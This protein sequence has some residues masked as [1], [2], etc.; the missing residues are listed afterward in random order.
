M[1]INRFSEKTSK[2]I[3]TAQFDIQAIQTF[4]KE[5]TNED[6]FQISKSVYTMIWFQQGSGDISIELDHF[7]IEESTLYYIKPGQT[8]N[9][10]IDQPAKGFIISF[11]KEFVELYE[12]NASELNNCAL[13][14]H[15]WTSPV[16][17]INEETN[18]FMKNI[19]DKMLQEFK[20]CFELRTEVLKSFLKIFIIYLSRQFENNYQ[21]P[22]KPRKMEMVNIF[23]TVLE[24]NFATKKMVRDYAKILGVS[25]GYLN[26]MVKEISGFTASYHIQQRVILE[27]KR[28]AIFEGD[29][30]KEISYYLGFCDPA[31][32]S[33]YFKNTSGKNFT[34]FKK[35]A[36]SFC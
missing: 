32:F 9:A 18:S 4:P 35:G 31:H 6:A 13:F 12:K 22:F 28:R 21:N 29:S 14:N 34:E 23:Y 2:N 33:K 10:K 7:V 20:N 36:F 8:L 25:P 19:A 15:F 16:I 3:V 27:A 1:N 26:D 5:I 24:K 17:R 30:L 11:A